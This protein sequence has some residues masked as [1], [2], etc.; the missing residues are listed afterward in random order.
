MTTSHFLK[1]A[2]LLVALWLTPFILGKLGR[3]QYGIYV[4][5]VS[6]AGW[7]RVCD[8]GSPAALQT[9]LARFPDN[10]GAASALVTAA[11]AA[12]LLT[13]LA[14]CSIGLALAAGSPI[15]AGLTPSAAHGIVAVGALLA[16]DAGV[17]L[18]TKV[19]SAVLIA[20]QQFHRDNLVQLAAM[21]MRVLVTV[22][23]LLEGWGLTA[24]AVA[25]LSGSLLRLALTCFESRRIAR[26][27]IRPR[28]LSRNHLRDI[29]GLG[30]WFSVGGLAGL[31]I[32]SADL[33][34]AAELI[35][36]ESV[37][38]LYLTAR[39]YDLAEGMF[40][41]VVDV[42]RPVLGA[43][44][45]R[46]ETSKAADAY[47]KLESLTMVFALVLSASIWA[48]NERFVAAWVGPD[49]YGGI[50]LNTAL[51][52]AFVVN[53]WVLPKRAVLSAALV[54]KPQSLS[55]LGEGVVKIVLGILL[56]SRFGLPG[57]VAA[58]SLA[59]LS[60]SV[61]YLERLVSGVFKPLGATEP[62]TLRMRPLV[63]VPV[64]MAVAVIG[65]EIT[66]AVGGYA[67]VTLGFIATAIAGSC[68]I[69]TL[70]IDHQTRSRLSLLVPVLTK[71]TAGVESRA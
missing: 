1:G 58:T 32:L 11:F 51:A 50:W 19:F 13:A 34:L 69:W 64:L 52:A 59:S 53:L 7:L 5:A 16:L 44:L 25:L 28:L 37:A 33:I 65:W 26:F 67:G 60:N 61:W 45:G 35:S 14:A 23:L 21:G 30:M 71:R 47:R 3:E 70:G 2:S 17:S 29:G 27:V 10:G 43:L 12:Q 40:K 62:F 4:L 8:F 68:M 54:V 36:I 6:V 38:V 55:R 22:V 66:A 56:G 9:R 49:N 42:A 63:F 20:R 57:I 24:L 31:M 39:L 46:G 15:L 48:V 41:P 18:L